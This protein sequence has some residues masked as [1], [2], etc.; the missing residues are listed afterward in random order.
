MWWLTIKANT[1]GKYTIPVGELFI[2]L[3][4]LLKEYKRQKEINEEHQKLNGELQKNLLIMKI[5][6]TKDERTRKF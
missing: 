1:T 2:T 6:R 4:K 5:R 3:E